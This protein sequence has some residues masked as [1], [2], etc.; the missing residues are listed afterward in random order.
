MITLPRSSRI[1]SRSHEKTRNGALGS[2]IRYHEA[3]QPRG[4]NA[5]FITITG[6]DSLRIR[7]YE[8]GVEAETLACGTGIV[9]S[10]LLAAK[11]CK[12]ATPVKITCAGGDVLTVDFTATDE[13]ARQVTLQGP[14]VFVFQGAVRVNARHPGINPA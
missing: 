1:S 6:P 11:Q 14:A 3:F 7:T 10:G 8:R 5:N 4:T 9:A 13:G 2:A 12:V